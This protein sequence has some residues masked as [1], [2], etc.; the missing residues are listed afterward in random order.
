[1]FDAPIVV[2]E[3]PRL[4][5]TTQSYLVDSNVFKSEMA[6]QLRSI[7]YASL[8]LAI[9]SDTMSFLL[10]DSALANMTSDG[11]TEL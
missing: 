2:L 6:L 5:Y 9:D 10:G 11:S 8:G 4:G 1:M 7:A 3:G